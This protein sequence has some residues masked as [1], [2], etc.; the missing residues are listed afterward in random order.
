MLPAQPKLASPRHNAGVAL[1]ISL[2]LLLMLTILGVSAVQSTSLEARMA[3]NDHDTLLAFQ[4]AESALRDAEDQLEAI[5]SIVNFTDAGASGLWTV[6]DLGTTPR[7]EDPD[8][9]SNGA[10]HIVAPTNVDGVAAEPM[11]IIEHAA[12]V[13]REENA[14][15]LD[16]P[17]GQS[18]SDRIEIFRITAVGTGGSA[19]A[20]VLLQSTYGRI[21]E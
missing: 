4:A 1:F 9:W 15:Q 7:W 11:Y 14:Y 17:Y 3:R 13:V 5:T 19:Q 10:K 12:S 20:R 2:V 21:M 8:T 6:A 18:A 16:D